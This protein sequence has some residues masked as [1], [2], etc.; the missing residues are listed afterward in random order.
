MQQTWQVGIIG[1]TS[2]TGVELARLLAG[3][4]G[5][6]LTL[7]TATGER[8]GQ[9]LA[10]LFPSL[11]GLCDLICEPP[12]VEAIAARCDLVFLALP[13]GRALEMVPALLERGVKVCDL[14]ADFRLRDPAAYETWYKLPHTAVPTLGEAVYGLPEWQR[15][16]IC[17]ARLVANP[18]CY[19]TSAILPLAPLLTAGLIVPDSIIVDSASGTSGA[20]RSSFGLGMHHPEITGDFKAYNIGTHRH[21]PEIE[22]GL[23][24]ALPPGTAMPPISFTTHL[25]PITRGILT[26]SY[27]TLT[28]TVTTGAVL[29]CLHQRYDDEPFVRLCPEGEFPQVKYVRGSNYCDIGVRVDPRTGRVVVIS[30]I[31]NLVKGASGQAIQN[32]NLM[33]GQEETLGL[34]AP[35]LFP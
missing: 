13:H 21:T 3:H 16:A 24:D 8:A 35:P 17:G 26:T 18:G 29:E 1:A 14:G 2:Y 19:P 33:L 27:A 34:L 25:L 7:V 12:E 5:A 15:T 20:G 10:S 23:Q 4:P 31:D 30:A 11:R 6:R 32:M 9:P 28:G 22:Q